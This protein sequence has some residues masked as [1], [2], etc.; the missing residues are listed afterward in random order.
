MY[1]RT[2]LSNER[3]EQ[4]CFYFGFIFFQREITYFE[5]NAV[6]IQQLLDLFHLQMN[7]AQKQSY[8]I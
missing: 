2:F 6:K 7:F 8:I 5:K 1:V 4:Y 3:F